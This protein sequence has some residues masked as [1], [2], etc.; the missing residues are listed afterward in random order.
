MDLPI[1]I[2][3]NGVTQNEFEIDIE[4]TMKMIVAEIMID[5]AMGN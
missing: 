1:V 3:T 2:I 5:V 4:D